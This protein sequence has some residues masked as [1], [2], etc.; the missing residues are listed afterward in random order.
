[1]REH[2]ERS[3]TCRRKLPP[4]VKRRE[5]GGILGSTLVSHVGMAC[6][7]QNHGQ[8]PSVNPRTEKTS[9]VDLRVPRIRVS[10]EKDRQSAGTPRKLT[11]GPSLCLQVW[12]KAYI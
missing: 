10:L 8:S 11:C 2:T 1:M 5:T 3:C 4:R 12:W 7:H 6:N 9:P